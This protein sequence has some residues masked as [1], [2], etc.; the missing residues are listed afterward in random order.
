MSLLRSGDNLLNEVKTFID[1]SDRVTIFSPFIRL[2]KLQE[3]L[4]DIVCTNI[5]VRWQTSDILF[6]VTDFENLYDYCRANDISLFRNVNIHLKVIQN[7]RNEIIYGSSNITNKGMGE[8]NFNLELSGLEGNLNLQDLTYLRKIINESDL[9]DETYFL[10]LKSKI[11]TKRHEIEIPAK[12]EEV[13]LEPKIEDHFLLS[14]LPMSETPTLLFEIYSATNN[15]I[16]SMEEMNCAIHDLANYSITNELEE[17]EFY[18]DL[19]L[20]FNTHPFIVKLKNEI[21]H[22]GAMRYGGVVNWIRENTTTVPTP[23]NWELKKEQIVN[24]LYDWICFFDSRYT[25]NRPNHSQV[26][27]FN[28]N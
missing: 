27:Y 15:R 10:N 14:A 28:G 12:I 5:I 24:I 9:V 13:V 17:N 21:R 20:A 8:A 1:R 22:Q 11:D 4:G 7:E 23:R 18:S 25:W 16:F 2:N 3:I 26:I 19:R 6:E